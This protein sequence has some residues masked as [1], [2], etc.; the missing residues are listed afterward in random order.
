MDKIWTKVIEIDMQKE[1]DNKSK[2]A[3]KST[4]LCISQTCS[5]GQSGLGL[6]SRVKFR[7]WVRD[8]TIITGSKDNK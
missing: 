8:K 2:Q 4:D 5:L 1:N 3:V 7:T 6:Q